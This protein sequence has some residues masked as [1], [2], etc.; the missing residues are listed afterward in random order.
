MSALMHSPVAGWRHVLGDNRG[1]AWDV[2]AD[3][4]RQQA[5]KQIVSAAS[6]RTDDRREMAAGAPAV[7]ILR[8]AETGL[9]GAVSCR[10][11]WIFDRSLGTQMLLRGSVSKACALLGFSVANR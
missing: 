1:I 11:G 7:A 10:P 6:R 2:A 9:Q 5:T 4:V 3:V 8:P